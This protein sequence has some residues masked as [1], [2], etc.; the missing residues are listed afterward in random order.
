MVRLVYLIIIC[1]IM[2]LGCSS[3]KI[4]APAPQAKPSEV[5]T[6]V[7]EVGDVQPPSLQ[8][9]RHEV[10]AAAP[11]LA[12]PSTPKNKLPE[13]TTI[14]LKPRLVYPG[15]KVKAE[16]EARD[17]DGDTVSYYYEWKRNDDFL[18]GEMLDEIGTT[19]FKKGDFITVTVTPHDG[20]E[21]GKPRRSLPLIV[22]N[23]PPEI[24]SS[25]PSELSNGIYKYEVKAAD[26]DGDK[27]SFSIEGAPSGM[28]IDSATG[29]IQWDVPQPGTY[30]IKIEAS[31][32]DAKAFQGFELSLTK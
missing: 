13:I 32:G 26:P 29:T 25:A 5:Q 16:P 20:K 3:E 4:E 17:E 1:G 14:R 31:D 30:S 24:T 19:G 15:T 8:E 9:S 7:A 28:T 10:A 11:A 2:T 12:T 27:L 21:K 18:A 22:A 23:R 6:K